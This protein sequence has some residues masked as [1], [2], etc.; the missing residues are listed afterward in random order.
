MGSGPGHKIMACSHNDEMQGGDALSL[1]LSLGYGFIEVDTHLGPF[2][3]TTTQSSVA[4]L[5][6]LE[7]EA[8]VDVSDPDPTLTLLAGHETKDL[9]TGRTLQALYFDPLLRILEANNAGR[10]VAEDGWVGLYKDDPS[11]GVVLMIDMKLDGEAIWPYLTAALRPFLSRGLL[12][13]YDVATSTWYKGPL[14]I[15]GTG[16]TPISHVYHQQ[17]RYIFYDAPLLQLDKPVELSK[18]RAGPAVTFE[19]DATLSP[20]ASSKL[21]LYYYLALT[22]SGRSESRKNSY[23]C[24][25]SKIHAVAQGKGIQSRWWGVARYPGFLRRRMWGVVR[26]AGASVINGDDLVELKQW[27]E[28]VNGADLTRDT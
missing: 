1:A 16:S 5:P 4:S 22:T 20:I 8:S 21:P 25:L 24:E 15:V 28:A 13:T 11:A 27:L 17:L 3:P 26:R 23:L 10:N 18:S 2:V 14:T 6:L 19:W 9:K 12:T 7:G